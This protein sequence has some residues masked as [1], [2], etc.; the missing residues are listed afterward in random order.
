MKANALDVFGQL[1]LIVAEQFTEVVD[2]VMIV[3]RTLISWKN[4]LK[5]SDIK[6]LI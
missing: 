4:S 2:D 5:Y 6:F 1:S 3:D